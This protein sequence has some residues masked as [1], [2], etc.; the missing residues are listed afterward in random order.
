MVLVSTDWISN[1]SRVFTHGDVNKEWPGLKCYKILT[2]YLARG[3][4][5]A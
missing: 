2:S 5:I 4:G 1:A 3:P